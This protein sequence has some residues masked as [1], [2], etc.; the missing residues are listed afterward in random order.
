MGGGG[1]E[2]SRIWWGM[3]EGQGVT[4]LVGN[5]RGIGREGL[6]IHAMA[7]PLLWA[8]LQLHVAEQATQTQ[9]RVVSFSCATLLGHDMHHAHRYAASSSLIV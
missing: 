7:V 6:D 1:G 4:T 5:T 8:Y 3:R 9:H 2:G